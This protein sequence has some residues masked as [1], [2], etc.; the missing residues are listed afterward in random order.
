MQKVADWLN[1]LGMSEYAQRFADNDIDFSILSELTDQDLEK[2]GVASLG[3][4]RKLLRAIASLEI[5][6]SQPTGVAATKLSP[7]DTA[8]RRQVTVMFSDLVGSTALSV[9]M[10][11]E[12][13]REVIST[14]QKCVAETVGRFGGFVAKFMGDG[15][16][17]YFGY[18]RAHEDDAERAVRA[19]LELVRT[20]AALESPISLQTRVG[21]ATGLV[22]VGDLI[23]SGEAQE[24]GIVGETPNLAARLQGIAAPD[25]VVVAESTRRLIGD[26]FELDALGERD[27]KGIGRVRLSVALRP[28][29]LE[30]RFDALHAG[31]LS[32]LLGREEETDLLLR[33]WR[34]A[35]GGEG[36]VVLV[37]GE[38]GIGKSHL[39]A[40]VAERAENN[41][42]M[43]LRY[44]CSSQHTNRTLFPITAH[45]ERAAALD[46][47]EAPA[48]K[49]AKV[50]A[51]LRRS[52]AEWP[53]GDVGLICELLSIAV[54]G[55][56]RSAL[57]PR[58][59]KERTL[60]LLLRLIETV[61]AR[62]P[63]LLIFEDVHWIDPTS[64]ELLV[65]LVERMIGWRVLLLITARPEFAPQWPSHSH[66][67]ALALTRL[68][69]RD[70]TTLVN[71][72]AG[73]K[74]LPAEVMDKIVSRADGVPLFLEELTKSVL[75]SDFLEQRDGQYVLSKPL[76]ALAIPTTL[77]GSL[78]ARLDRSA[79]AKEIAQ[80]GA[81]I[82]RE[83]S[84]ALLRAVTAMDEAALNEALG[85][86]EEANLA[87]CRGR[88]PEA[89]YS[90]KHAL[91][92]DTAYASLLKTRRQ[93]LHRQ[94]A[95]ALRDR[96]SSLAETEPE[97][98][99]HHFT[100]AG[101][102]EIA[103]EWWT[104]AGELALRRSAYVEA[105]SHY[106][107]AIGQAEQLS[108]GPQSLRRR[109]RLQIACGQALIS[110]RGH[111]APETTAAF[112]RA[113]ELA[114]AIDDPA[115]R[116]SVYYGLWA[117]GY[118]RGEH[119]T[120]E[121]MAEIMLR[122]IE[123]HPDRPESVVAYRVVGTTFWSGG[124][125]VKA[126]QYFDRA[127]AALPPE[128]DR[129]LA[130]RFGQD[131][132]V[133]AIAYFALVLFGL[134]EVDRARAL[135]EQA[136]GRA[137]RSG[138][139]PTIVYGQF[140]KAVFEAT[141]AGP[142]HTAPFASATLMLGREHGM[143]VW[144][145]IGT[146]YDC[147]ARHSTEDHALSELRRGLALCYEAGVLNWLAQMVVMQASAEGDAGHID[148]G[149]AR[150]SGFLAETQPIKQR[151][152]DSELY[153][154]RGTLLMR[155][156]PTEPESA[157]VAFKSALAIART[158]QTR[159]FELRAAVAL[160]R[161]WYD[162][163]KRE[164]ARALLAPVYAWFTQG[165]DTDD[166]KSAKALLDRLAS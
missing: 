157:E 140:L 121:E 141:A 104:K 89:T 135:A 25:T 114:A 81:A 129:S 131:P 118:V 46:Q 55:Q 29:A 126:R 30:G 151:W 83:F 95:E 150:I 52:G 110:A 77:Q 26:L 92:Q 100:Q 7:S 84:Y 91:V 82:G 70:G 132:A 1:N 105:V 155:R 6:K 64:E 17:I 19:G 3:H 56:Y 164:E 90:F 86:L 61:A 94:I 113:R 162:K 50:E 37:S 119:A 27:I 127:V 156:T 36:Q 59:R 9:R 51:M 14:Y 124:D 69:R 136:F 153:R 133:S 163:G 154:H 102:A 138:H 87:S 41:P 146:F 24:R 43:R 48:D 58:V 106:D 11:P 98:I 107:K 134:G 60:V 67:T 158:Q 18:P 161:L 130:M 32:A 35:Q 139:T 5:E 73:G 21:I 115:E 93:A 31:K 148:D 149:L 142:D 2:I 159:T 22:V 4:R 122:E 78:M 117:G 109:L 85:K 39:T 66:I 57:S 165:F 123:S 8:E 53:V 20:V 103:V 12:D 49:I 144:I 75:E 143:P 147:W 15:V 68:G 38:P 97:I 72:V 96:F 28:S 45:L 152:L 128:S 112:T 13:L 74:A 71:R 88:P 40:A 111:G 65:T 160:A 120:M 42:H 79:L 23:G 16:L 10:D 62:R 125:Y 44:F 80:I 47:N 166:L 34:R 137:L 116:F 54:D 99:A 76:P 108:E 63:V 101:L 145:A 33:R